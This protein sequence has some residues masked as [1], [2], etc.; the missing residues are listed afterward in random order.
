MLWWVECVSKAGSG[1][2]ARL[3]M[4]ESRCIEVSKSVRRS[5]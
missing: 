5:V 2:G 1:K 3:F 4:R